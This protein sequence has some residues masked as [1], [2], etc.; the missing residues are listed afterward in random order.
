MTGRE[1]ER[2]KKE[3]EGEGR[4]VVTPQRHL[5]MHRA[6][7]TRTCWADFAWLDSL[8]Q[9]DRSSELFTQQSTE[10][11]CELRQAQE[12]MVH[13]GDEIFIFT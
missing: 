1:R 9:E 10:K 11:G 6:Q 8:F 3:G 5:E 12:L 2:K 4:G 7:A 13:Q